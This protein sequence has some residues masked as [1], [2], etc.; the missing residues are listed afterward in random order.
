MYKCQMDGC[1]K[2]TKPR[3]PTNRI[4]TETREKIYEVFPKK[5]WGKNRD[6]EPKLV[7]G[8]E[9]VQE[10]SVCPE[11][12]T[13][14][15]GEE[16]RRIVERAPPVRREKPRDF[17]TRDNKPWRNPKNKSGTTKDKKPRRKPEV[18]VVNRPSKDGK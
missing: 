6:S 5:K 15:T 10:I 1:G 3:Q 2:V 7:R 14:A 17:K 12:Y 9:I 16:A 4:V 11:C 8:S 13:Q 18:Q